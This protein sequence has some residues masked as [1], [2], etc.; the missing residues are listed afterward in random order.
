MEDKTSPHYLDANQAKPNGEGSTPASVASLPTNAQEQRFRQLASQWR[1]EVA[2]LSSSVQMAAHP[3]YREI[4]AMGK[5]AIPLLLAE[6][7]RA[8]HFWFAALRALTGEN[9]VPKEIAGQVKAMARAWIQWGKDK[10]H[11][12]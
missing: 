1:K 12:Q 7:Q 6:L 5:P 9:P 11:V 8:P 2:H 3:A 10:G 4:I